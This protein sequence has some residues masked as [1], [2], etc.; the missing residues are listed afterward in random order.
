M[1][2][3][4]QEYDLINALSLH[5]PTLVS[6]LMEVEQGYVVRAWHHCAGAPR[7][8]ARLTTDHT[9]AATRITTRCMRRMWCSA[10]FSS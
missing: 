4:L 6:F 2:R 7:S 1:M 3:A 10:C 5:K 9:S 8:R